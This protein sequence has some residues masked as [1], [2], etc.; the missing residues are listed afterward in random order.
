MNTIWF[1]LYVQSKNQKKQETKQKQSYIQRTD[2]W[3]SDEKEIGFRGEK[4]E[5]IKKYKL[6]V[7]K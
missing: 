3:L 5:E 1:H 2:W 7:A 6:V 4:G